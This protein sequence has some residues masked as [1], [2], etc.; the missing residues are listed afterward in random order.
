MG[1]MKRIYGTWFFLAATALGASSALKAQTAADTVGSLPGIEITTAVDQAE[2]F[3]GDPITYTLTIVFDSAYQLI[4]VPLGANLGAFDVKDFEPDVESKLK[5][6][7]IQSRTR[8][9]LSTFTTGDYVIPPLPV[10]FQLADSTRKVVLSESIPIRIQSLLGDQAADSLDIKPLRAPYEFPRDYTMYYVYGALSLLALG[11]L[12]VL[13]WRLRRRRRAT[14]PEDLRD[15]WEVAFEKLAFLKTEYL[16][17]G[18]DTQERCKEYY[19]EVTEIVRAYLGR[20]HRVDVLEMTTEEVL[21]RFADEDLPPG[22][23]DALQAFLNHADQVKF[24]KLL[25]PRTRLEEDFLSAHTLVETVR[26]DYERRRQA[27]VNVM[28]GRGKPQPEEQPV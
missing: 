12:G 27:E 16:D 15:P 3:I 4:P 5:G 23:H 24:A 17:T 18:V 1:A 13:W 8:F 22:Q 19:T 6:G 9:V 28:N 7:R 11:G 25:A 14:V 26:A 10:M 20:M 21:Q 2:A